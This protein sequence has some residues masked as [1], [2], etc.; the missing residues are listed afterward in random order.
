MILCNGEIIE[1]GE[2]GIYIIKYLVFRKNIV[3]LGILF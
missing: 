3:N 1:S 2:K